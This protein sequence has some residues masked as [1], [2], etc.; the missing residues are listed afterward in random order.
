MK[1]WYPVAS[2]V[3]FAPHPGEINSDNYASVGSQQYFPNTSITASAD[4]TNSCPRVSSTPTQIC[5]SALCHTSKNWNTKWHYVSLVRKRTQFHCKWSGVHCVSMFLLR[6]HTNLSTFN[7]YK[8]VSANQNL[9][10]IVTHIQQK[11]TKPLLQ[12]KLIPNTKSRSIKNGFIK[13]KHHHVHARTHTHITYTLGWMPRILQKNTGGITC[14]LNV[15]FPVY[16]LDS[17]WLAEM[18]VLDRC[19]WK[20]F[21]TSHEPESGSGHTKWKRTIFP[22]ACVSRYSPA[23][24]PEASSQ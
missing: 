21:G 9:L 24:Y 14:N 7:W 4:R 16:S 5:S 3:T 1:N 13:K 12:P 19:T 17:K 18:A 10:Y 15:C 23:T 8:S 2:F 20:L 11:W 6:P 22:E